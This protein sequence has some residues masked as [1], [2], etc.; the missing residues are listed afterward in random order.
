MTR[1]RTFFSSHAPIAKASCTL[2]R[3]SLL[4]VALPPLSHDI[5]AFGIPI[6]MP[7]MLHICMPVRAPMR[8]LL[9][10]LKLVRVPS[11]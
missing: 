7:I 11:S 8:V 2:S 4:Y 3:A 9:R 6:A 10:V 5:L 1:F